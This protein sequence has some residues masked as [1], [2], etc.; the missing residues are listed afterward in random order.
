MKKE[1]INTRGEGVGRVGQGGDGKR[2]SS[3]YYCSI[4]AA[5][6]M[7]TAVASYYFLI[8]IF[9]CSA[10]HL[11]PSRPHSFR[12]NIILAL[13]ICICKYNTSHFR[14]PDDIPFLRFST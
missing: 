10:I 9:F 7:E 11:L 8:L 1:L 2:Q 12:F 4:L 13:C 6:R 3:W 14:Q 5:A